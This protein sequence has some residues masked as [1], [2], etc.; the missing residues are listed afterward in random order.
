MA[1]RLQLPAQPQLK[2]HLSTAILFNISCFPPY[3]VTPYIR[4]MMRHHDLVTGTSI[5]QAKQTL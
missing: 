3:P 1:R 2:E 4:N 5:F